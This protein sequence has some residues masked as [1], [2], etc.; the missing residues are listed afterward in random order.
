MSIRAITFDFWQTLFREDG[1]ADARR[2]RRIRAFC[3]ASG[4]D[5]EAAAKAHDLATAEFFRTHIEEQRNLGPDD[6]VR[7]MCEACA[8]SIAPSTAEELAEIA[9]QP[10][11]TLDG[12]P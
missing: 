9:E 11:V 10:T 8:L 7:L 6:G 3:D 5:L 12:T 1:H 4:V 2:M